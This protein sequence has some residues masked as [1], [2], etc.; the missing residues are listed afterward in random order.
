MMKMLPRVALPPMSVLLLPAEEDV[1]SVL[2]SD[3]DGTLWKGLVAERVP[4]L[5]F[6]VRA[7]LAVVDSDADEAIALRRIGGLCRAALS[8]WPDGVAVAL[9][10]AAKVADVDERFLLRVLRE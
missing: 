9:R 1:D 8:C 6:V 3:V 5:T 2:R 4:W 7:E 10:E